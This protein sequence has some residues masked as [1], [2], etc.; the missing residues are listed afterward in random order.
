MPDLLKSGQ[1]ALHFVMTEWVTR[2]QCFFGQ[3]DRKVSAIA[4]A[5]L[6]EHG[7]TTND[8]RL[9]AI[10]VKGDPIIDPNRPRMTRSQR[11]VD[12][13]TQIPLLV[14]IFKLLIHE[15]SYAALNE[16]ESEGDDSDS[17]D[18]DKE[19]NYAYTGAELDIEDAVLNLD[20]PDVVNDPLFS[21]D[22]EGYLKQFLQSFSTCVQYQE[23]CRHAN[24][25]EVKVLKAC[26]I[27]TPTS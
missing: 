22:L 24:D 5:K 1:S 19:N 4:L 26:Q 11:A 25:A 2:Q 23:F 27:P 6:L 14:K 18:D 16:C 21:V 20:D 12:Q 10:Q 9:A 8:P 7:V 15:L 3:F 17:E 13:W